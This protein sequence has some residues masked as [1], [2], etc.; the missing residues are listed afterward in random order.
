MSEQLPNVSAYP[1]RIV[2]KIEETHMSQ[3]WLAET[4]RANQQ[5]AGS[6]VVLKIALRFR[7]ET[8]TANQNAIEN[9]QNWLRRLHER[10]SHPGIVR[11]LP[12]VYTGDKPVFIARTQDPNNPWFIVLDYLAGGSLKANLTSQLLSVRQSLHI[13]MQLARALAFV[14]GHRCVHLD[15][16]P[17]N[18]VFQQPLGSKTPLEL[19]RPVLIDFGI[20]RAQDEE[21]YIGGASAWLAPECEH[22]REQRI[23]LKIHPSMDIYPLGCILHYLITGQHPNTEKGGLGAITPAHLQRDPAILP[24]QRAK[25]TE[26]LSNL[27]LHMIHVEPAQRPDAQQ[28]GQELEAILNSLQVEAPRPTRWRWLL[29]AVPALLALLAWAMFST[30]SPLPSNEP[31]RTKLPTRT[32]TV[33]EVAQVVSPLTT[34]TSTVTLTLPP[35][36]TPTLAV[37]AALSATQSITGSR[38][39]T[40]ATGISNNGTLSKSVVISGAV[41]LTPTLAISKSVPA[42]T[43]APLST[44][45]V[46]ATKPISGTITPTQA[47]KPP[48]KPTLKPTSTRLAT[49][50]PP[51]TDTA[52]ATATILVTTPRAQSRPTRT[53]RQVQLTAPDANNSFRG[54]ALFAWSAPFALGA[55]EFFE[56]AFWQQGTDRVTAFGLEQASKSQQVSINLAKYHEFHPDR[57]KSGITYLWAVRVVDRNGRLIEWVSEARSFTFAE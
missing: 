7:T 51:P 13:V 46:T 20:A 42:P 41:S 29:G 8:F 14:H 27:I 40:Q 17:D 9:E 57:L 10:Q 49:P 39:I 33:A 2:R 45:T 55:N 47:A 50:T 28:I 35:P 34:S 26:Q 54:S 18:I 5:Q 36:P 37:S 56:V 22:A 44:A 23:R 15:I 43:L 30:A 25:L 6:R 1:F 24:R 3:T 4:Q 31:S 38:A 19:V 52:T 12:V 11:I 53:Q 21:H 48:G 32:P 16:K